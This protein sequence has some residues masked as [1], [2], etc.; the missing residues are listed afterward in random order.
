MNTHYH[1]MV[2]LKSLEEQTDDNENNINMVIY[3]CHPIS[4]ILLMQPY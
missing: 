4:N 1:P 3:K 2:K